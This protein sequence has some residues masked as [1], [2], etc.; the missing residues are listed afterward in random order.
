MN[1][2]CRLKRQNGAGG[3]SCFF[4]FSF[5]IRL[6]VKKQLLLFRGGEAMRS[7]GVDIKTYFRTTVLKISRFDSLAF[8]RFC[9]FKRFA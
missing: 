1:A 6:F 4:Y 8:P 7:S 5:L 3:A 9:E 2:G